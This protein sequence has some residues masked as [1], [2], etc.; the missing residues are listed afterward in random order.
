M[1]TLAATLQEENDYQAGAACYRQG[2]FFEAHEHWEL[3]WKRLQG[4]RRALVQGLI[5]VAAAWVKRSRGEALG[6]RRLLTSAQQ[7]FDGLPGALWGADVNALRASV[8]RCLEAAILWE[9]DPAEPVADSLVP[10]LP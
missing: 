7:R 9:K 6:M 10:S 1:N 3:L 4:D 8:E 2:E 5:Q